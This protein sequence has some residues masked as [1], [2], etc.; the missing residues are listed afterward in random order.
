MVA[1]CARQFSFFVY[2]LVEKNSRFFSICQLAQNRRSFFVV[3]KVKHN[4]NDT[5]FELESVINIR[6]DISSLSLKIA[7]RD[8]LTWCLCWSQCIL[9]RILHLHLLLTR[10]HINSLIKERER[11]RTKK[12]RSIWIEFYYFGLFKQFFHCFISNQ[13]IEWNRKILN[14]AQLYWIENDFFLSIQIH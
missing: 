2:V 8:S 6:L 11:K 1:Y 14:F 12:N 7:T 4:E 5:S 13:W 10:F 9:I 3:R